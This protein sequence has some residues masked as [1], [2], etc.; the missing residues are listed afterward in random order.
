MIGM[1]LPGNRGLYFVFIVILRWKRDRVLYDLY[2]SA[3]AKF[4][5]LPSFCPVVYSQ[6]RVNGY[7]FLYMYGGGGSGV[8]GGMVTSCAMYPWLCCKRRRCFQ[9]GAKRGSAVEKI[10]KVSFSGD[11][12]S[13]QFP[14]R[15]HA[16][17]RSKRQTVCAPYV[18][19]GLPV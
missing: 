17:C 2:D 3:V 15:L 6:C 7:S 13:P 8:G 4:L 11:L 9:R 12:N 19:V 1:T 5:C 16:Y 10:L 18:K 14:L